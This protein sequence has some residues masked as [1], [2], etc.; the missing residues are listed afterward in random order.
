MTAPRDLSQTR[1]FTS[2]SSQEST[3]SHNAA[4]RG[5]TTAFAR[6][7]ANGKLPNGGVNPALAAATSAGLRSPSP[8][9]PIIPTST[10]ESVQSIK[11]S[12]TNMSTPSLPLPPQRGLSR[13]PS[14]QAASLATARAAQPSLDSRPGMKSDNP[15]TAATK[16]PAVPPKPRRLS[17]YT[18]SAEKKEDD[19]PT[20]STP[21]PPTT[22]L[23]NMFEQKASSPQSPRNNV[24]P[25]VVKPNNELPLKS[26]K[27]VRTSSGIT[28]MI[29]R[30]LENSRTSPPPIANEFAYST[31]KAT[32]KDEESLHAS[33]PAPTS[34][35]TSALKPPIP[36]PR[37]RNT[38]A[39]AENTH[40]EPIKSSNDTRGR[41]VPPLSPLRS[42]TTDPIPINRTI[43]NKSLTSPSEALSPS[44]ASGKSIAA[45]W[46]LLHPRKGTPNMTGNQLADAM[47]AGSLASS[48]H[49]SP[50]RS[51]I[52][53]PPLPTR[54][55]KHHTFSLS[56]EPSPAKQGM[57]KTLRQT[58]SET[59]DEGEDERLYPYSKHKVQK[60]LGKHP[61][62]HHEG[63]RKRWRE[64]VT[65]RERKRYEGVWAA[66]KGMYCVFTREEQRLISKE[67]DSQHV[68]DLKEALPD[69]VSN[70][71]V[72]DIWSRSR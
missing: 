46:N 38:A 25:I 70:L 47:V 66:N 6:P 8:A 30:E 16:T 69:Q 39:G 2:V 65:E 36:P 5:A 32:Q 62:K 11:S 4:L 34:K 26:P 10:G 12:V 59:S 72:R 55:H 1:S 53:P 15:R 31:T 14:Q 41:S 33:S 23:V 18:R 29:Q 68:R 63:D 52:E 50:T 67:P 28:S 58:Q 20:D 57:R 27:P 42:N 21:I 49:P 3:N 64:E 60:R 45:Q 7:A 44:S 9:R 56:R 35:V 40:L 48:R 51:T 54:R 17:S 24:D 22:S 71:I 61:N 19:K 37:N 13:S 43:T